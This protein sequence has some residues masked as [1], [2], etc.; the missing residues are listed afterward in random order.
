MCLKMQKYAKINMFWQS[1]LWLFS[2]EAVNS[3]LSLHLLYFL[4]Q[5]SSPSIS[6]VELLI[7][8]PRVARICGILLSAHNRKAPSFKDKISF[9]P[10]DRYF[11]Q[12]TNLGIVSV[13]RPIFLHICRI[14][15]QR[16]R[17]RRTHTWLLYFWPE[18][19]HKLVY[20]YLY[21]WPEKNVANTIEFIFVARK[22]TKT[23]IQI[24]YWLH[25]QMYKC[26]D[27]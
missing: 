26:S 14:C 16:E 19:S 11:L 20:R 23:Y 24:M 17:D 27:A 21:L 18:K 15:G 7:C 5:Q 10:T 4:S 12:C 9:S 22:T 3:V 25:K 13:L 6:I 2:A 8:W 1:I